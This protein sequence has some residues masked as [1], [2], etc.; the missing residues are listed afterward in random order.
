MREPDKPA[1]RDEAGRAGDLRRLEGLSRQQFLTRGIKLGG[2]A[3]AIPGLATIL[4][5]CGDSDEESTP[6]DSGGAASNADALAEVRQQLDA[7]R[8]IP[9]FKA[10]GPE[11]DISGVAGETV[12]YLPLLMGVPIV[13][14]WWRGV[15]DAGAA[16]GLK[17]VNFDPKGQA[18][19]MVRG[20]EQAIGQKVACIII[21]SIESSALA[22]PIRKAKAAGIKVLVVNERNES[23]GGPK[24]EEV[25][26]GLSLDYIGAAK[27]EADWCIDHSKG[28]AKVAVLKLPNAPAHDDMEEAIRAELQKYCPGECDVVAVEE[29]GAPEWPTRLPTL[30]R[31]LLTSHPDLNYLIPV[32]DAMSLPMVPA[33]RQ[34]GAADRVRIA[35]FNGT[36]AVE[37]LVEA[38]DVVGADVG[39]ANTW[40]AWAYIDQ[41]LRVMT[42][43][44]PVEQNVPLRMIDES[45]IGSID[46]DETDQ[47]SWYGTDAAIAGYKK[48]W[49]VS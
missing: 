39:G 45:N 14:T 17:T 31:S 13:Q 19:E 24:L 36:P 25:D 46:I 20:M 1:R 6:S 8:A 49:G 10:P 42:D 34:A 44:E 23:K 43:K 37:K 40:E 9:E 48:L 26:A 38:G 28:K 32:V 3:V 47:L 29:V 18:S 41:A 33:V 4:S 12:F 5:A 27:L 30:T 11:I 2:L 15:Q 21:D 16:A 7:A 22:E 35:T